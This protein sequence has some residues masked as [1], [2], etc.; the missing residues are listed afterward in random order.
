MQIKYDKCGAV[1]DTVSPETAKD[2]DIEHM[3]HNCGEGEDHPLHGTSR[4][5]QG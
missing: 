3:P 4:P 1:H 5:G 2:G